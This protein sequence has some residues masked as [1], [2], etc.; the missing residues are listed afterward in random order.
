MQNQPNAQQPPQ[1]PAPPV[2]PVPPQ[3]PGFA[4]IPGANAAILDYTTAGDRKYFGYGTRPLKA[5]YDLS[6]STLKAFLDAVQTRAHEF[7]WANILDIPDTLPAAAAIASKDLLTHYGQISLEHLQAVAATYVGQPTRQA[8]NAMML[9]LCLKKSLTDAAATRIAL[10]SAQY[11]VGG[12]LDGPCL[13]KAITLQARIDTQ[14]MVSHLR[15]QLNQLPL[16]LERNSSD[17]S[18]FNEGVED[19]LNS[20]DARGEAP[21]P[22]LGQKLLKAYRTASDTEFVHYI[23]CKQDEYDEHVGPPAL[24]SDTDLM[25]FARNKY[26]Q[27]I[28]EGTWNKPSGEQEKI[29]AL[30]AEIKQLKT[31]STRWAKT[32][33]EDKDKK[34]DK[35][36]VEKKGNKPDWMTTRGDGPAVKT[37]NEKEYHWCKWHKAWTRHEPKEC[38]LNPDAM[39]E[40]AQSATEEPAAE[41]APQM[42]LISALNAVLTE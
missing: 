42:R 5:D 26:L 39:E 40:Q 33:K 28:D 12:Q 13:L 2:Q 15:E 22:D 9:A 25:Q 4:L 11:M 38:R 23:R 24:F 35:P 3:V 6:T 14:Y 41:E 16:L 31:V 8:Q 29:I 10:K 18:K 21:G 32:Q 27:R 17:I 7:A 1:Q 34:T 36:K 19:I 20:L 30:Q 37:V